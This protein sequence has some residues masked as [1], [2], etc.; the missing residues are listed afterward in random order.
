MLYLTGVT[1][2]TVFHKVTFTGHT[3]T[4]S[5]VK[6]KSAFLGPMKRVRVT[7]LIARHERLLRPR[8]YRSGAVPVLF[9]AKDHRLGFSDFFGDCCWAIRQLKKCKNDLKNQFIFKGF[10]FQTCYLF[11]QF[12]FRNA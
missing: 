3:K 4:I 2:H 1:F 5:H 8:L 12:R 7:H 6:Q 11:G 10:R 9:L